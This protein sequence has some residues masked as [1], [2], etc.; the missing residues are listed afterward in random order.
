MVLTCH[1]WQVWNVI[2]IQ[3]GYLMMVGK[4][5]FDNINA[6]MNKKSDFICI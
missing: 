2:C 3:I 5:I 6:K 1:F 4:P